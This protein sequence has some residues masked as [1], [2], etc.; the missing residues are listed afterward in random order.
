MEP[1]IFLVVGALLALVVLRV[2]RKARPKWRRL[3][4]RMRRITGRPARKKKTPKK[5]RPQ[6]RPRPKPKPTE[7]PAASESGESARGAA[8]TATADPQPQ[9]SAAAAPWYRRVPRW[10]A[11]A[12]AG[13][14]AVVLAVLPL[15]APGVVGVAGPLLGLV[16]IVSA[17]AAVAAAVPADGIGGAR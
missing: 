3:V 9:E 15:V 10:V 12:A 11:P 16:L 14:S 1:L 5:S 13:V 6:G 4:A 2:V 7:T 8:A 17:T